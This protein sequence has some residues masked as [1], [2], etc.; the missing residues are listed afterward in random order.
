MEATLAELPDRAKLLAPKLDAP[1]LLPTY[2]EL[3]SQTHPRPHPDPAVAPWLHGPERGSPDVQVV[4]RADVDAE[5][6]E[7]AVEDPHVL[8]G[9]MATLEACP[10][11][12]QEALAVPVYA[13]QAWLC[14]GPPVEVADTAAT[15]AG[16]DLL[17]TEGLPALRWA[18]GDAQVVRA[19]DLAP[20]DVLVVPS[21][22][23]GL[24]DAG[25]WDPFAQAAVTDLGDRAQWQQRRRAVLRP[26]IYSCPAPTPFDADGD[27][28]LAQEQAQG[29]WIVAFGSAGTWQGEVA[30]HLRQV[31]WRWVELDG[32]RCALVGT[33]PARGRLDFRPTRSSLV[34]HTQTLAD[35][36][37]AVVN[38]VRA[39]AGHLGLATSLAGDLELAAWLH[40]LGKADPRFQH[41]LAGGDPVKA[42]SLAE[43][44]AKSS[45]AHQ[46]RRAR[47]A[48]AS[49]SGYPPGTRHELQSVALVRDCE[50]L[51]RLA[52]DWDLVLH[53]VGSHHG[54]CRPFAP[55]SPDPRPVN[56]QV[57]ATLALHGK[58]ARVC[59]VQLS[60]S[61][62]HGLAKV[63]SGIAARFAALQRRY[64]P[65]GLAWLEAV[66]RLADHRASEEGGAS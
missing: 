33:R 20:G 27:D 14:Q 23:G 46:D 3:W 26:H 66:L 28:P 49:R 63:G 22:Y 15:L 61:S 51:Q 1:V 9:L 34:G 10:P 17:G 19:A 8:E 42:A 12:S 31:G 7:R 41:L 53:L 43:P 32:T 11:A 30:A 35:H 36:T 16:H 55:A 54:W 44:L 37:T 13:A 40:D 57:Q 21:A 18:G 64:G 48:A 62:E 24:N 6:L 59:D 50:P 29:Q 38:H 52:T 56:V 65:R 5:Q 2:L 4:W 45:L 25:V 47:K 39:F 58:P 60:A